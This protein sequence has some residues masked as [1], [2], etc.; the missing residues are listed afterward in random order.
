MSIV[1]KF[2]DELVRINKSAFDPRTGLRASL[3]AIVPV[4]LGFAVHQPEL[5]LIGVGAIFLTNTEGQP[6]TLTL[7]VL[8][9]ATVMESLAFG[10]GRLVSTTSFLISATLLGGGVF[11]ALLL[12]GNP[13]WGQ[14]GTFVAVIFAVGVGLPD[15]ST[16]AAEIGALYLLLGGIWALLGVW[17]Q[18]RISVRG[19]PEWRAKLAPPQPNQAAQ[20]VASQPNPIE[21]ALIVA[22][23][24]ALGYVVATTFELPRDYWVV[25]IVITAV[26][27]NLGLTVS[28]TA[29][30]AVG[31]IVGALIAAAVVLGTNSPYL[32]A[33][34]LFAFSFL[35]FSTRGVNTV[36]L[37]VFLVPFII[38]LLNIIYPG[39]WYLALDRVL[40]TLIG[41]AIA[42]V[43]V[44]LLEVGR[45]RRRNPAAS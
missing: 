1:A 36:L 13:R 15:G 34:S 44:S 27:P 7:R 26:R 45:G 38:I 8:F 18:R 9:G 6:S 43:V 35:M 23:A 11:L 17:L 30:R 42:I 14:V 3:S 40:D 2:L 16:Q 21:T 29:A 22:V 19:H 32:L 5:L 20:S 28:F 4:I 10:L 25:V 41:G 12:R 31:S 37:Q 24:A 33:P 39:E